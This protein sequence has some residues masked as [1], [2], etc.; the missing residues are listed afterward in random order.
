MKITDTLQ[1]FIHDH[2][3]DDLYEL[4]L[5]ASRY[6]NVDV[7]AAVVQI[8]ARRQLKDKLPSWN[9]MDNLFF[10]STLVAEQCSSEVTAM[11]KQNLICSRDCICDLTGGLGVD[12]Y[13]FSKKAEYVVYVEKDEDYCNA[14]RHNFDILETS[15]V[16]VVNG[17]AIDLVAGNDSRV[18]GANFF[19]ID[20][21]RRGSGNKRVF[22]ISDCIPD[23]AILWPLLREKQCRIVVKLS[24]M[25]DITQAITQLQGVC[26]V[27]IVSVKNECKEL[28]ILSENGTTLSEKSDIRIVCVNFKSDGD[29]QV[30]R[31]YLHDEHSA[32]IHLAERV[33]RYLY[34]PNSSILKAGAYKSVSAHFGVEKLNVSSHLYTSDNLISSFPGRIFEVY[35]VIPFGSRIYKAL[36]AEVPQANITVRNFPLS[37]EELRKLT[38]I[39][40]GGEVYLF[41]TTLSDSKK[42]IIK[43]RK[44]LL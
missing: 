27:H 20:P 17:D 25:L 14:A 18:S 22:A 23:M 6:A 40:D 37:A 19:Y 44:A 11:Y 34:E 31:F 39:A 35:D 28:L 41:A 12:T 21:A 38:H 5:S 9:K 26:E 7:E 29:E 43:C 8:K 2:A 13:F 1:K 36:F 4:L 3:N 10:P 33:G 24:P 15:N 42:V 30:F 32:A 16:I